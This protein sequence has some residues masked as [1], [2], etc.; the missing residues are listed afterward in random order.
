[1][2]SC[3]GPALWHSS[4]LHIDS[5]FIEWKLR[6]MIPPFFFSF[7]FFP[8]FFFSDGQF[9]RD[10]MSQVWKGVAHHCQLLREVEDTG[11]VLIPIFQAKEN[12]FPSSICSFCYFRLQS[13]KFSFILVFLY[14]ALAR[15]RLQKR[16]ENGKKR[17]EG[18]QRTLSEP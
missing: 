8:I 7:L 2:R 5:L 16:Q 10:I 9:G 12:R 4:Y 15:T 6:I 14:P 1:M 13:L 11:R 17:Q 18:I 3:F